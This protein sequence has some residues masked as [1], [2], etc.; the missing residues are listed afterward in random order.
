MITLEQLACRLKRVC[1]VELGRYAAKMAISMAPQDSGPYVL[2][3]NIYASNGMWGDVE[4]LRKGLESI[5]AAK[6]PG[7]SWIEVMKEVHVFIARGN[8]HKETDSIYL[9][10]NG[11]T[12][13]MRGVYQIAI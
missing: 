10:L 6:E 9:L 13:L 4:K 12:Q 3:S 7:Y 1:N 5:G 8:E 2:M 11:L